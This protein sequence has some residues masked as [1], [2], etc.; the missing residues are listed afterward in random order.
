MAIS[1]VKL[2][3]APKAKPVGPARRK[4]KAGAEIPDSASHTVVLTTILQDDED[5]YREP[6][7][8]I[9]RP[10]NQVSRSMEQLKQLISARYHANK[11]SFLAVWKKVLTYYQQPSNTDFYKLQL[12]PE[13]LLEDFTRVLTANDPNVPNN[14]TKYNYK[15][16]AYKQDPEGPMDHLIFHFQLDGCSLHRESEDVVQQQEFEA[17]KKMET[18]RLRKEA[19]QEAFE[20]IRR[21]CF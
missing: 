2:Q 1:R 14:I 16:K 8:R 21:S 4:S 7:K 10:E 11:A 9:V 3:M 6:I 17:N 15:E 12:S 19:A 13:Q 18:D 20:V 5:F